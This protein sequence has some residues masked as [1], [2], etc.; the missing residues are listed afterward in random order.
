MYITFNQYYNDEN[1]NIAEFI[2]NTPPN[3]GDGDIYNFSGVYL[4]QNDVI[5]FRIEVNSLPS[6]YRIAPYSC[7]IEI[8]R[9]PCHIVDLKYT[10]NNIDFISSDG[11]IFHNYINDYK[12]FLAK[13]NTTIRI[14]YISS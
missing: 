4:I 3:S 8:I 1:H 9:P 6:E 13:V 2:F 10:T 12:S 5:D 7:S 14:C 11:V